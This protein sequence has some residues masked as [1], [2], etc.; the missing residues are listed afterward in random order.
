M[1]E[2]NFLIKIGTSNGNEMMHYINQLKPGDPNYESMF[3]LDFY[4]NIFFYSKFHE[5]LFYV[6]DENNLKTQSGFLDF[7]YHYLLDLFI[8]NICQ[9]E[10][11]N[12]IDKCLELVEDD[13]GVFENEV[14]NCHEEFID[15]YESCNE[16]PLELLDQLEENEP[17]KITENFLESMLDVKKGDEKYSKIY[18]IDFYGNVLY[19]SKEEDDLFWEEWIHWDGNSLEC[20]KSRGWYYYFINRRIMQKYETDRSALCNV[21]CTFQTEIDYKKEWRELSLNENFYQFK[22]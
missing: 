10:E 2:T 19:Y 18:L 15:E 22:N 1:K 7:D 11:D 12:E 5:D 13:W 8:M 14:D 6:F 21:A 17:W 20:R 4:G 3:S 16:I 9:N